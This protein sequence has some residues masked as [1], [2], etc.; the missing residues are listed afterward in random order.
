MGAE[1]FE[2]GGGGG[3]LSRDLVQ[4]HPE[5]SCPWPLSSP[6]D[7]ASFCRRLTQVWVP[8]ANVF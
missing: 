4:R 3:G 6:N 2:E 1:R 7:L 5:W 8:L